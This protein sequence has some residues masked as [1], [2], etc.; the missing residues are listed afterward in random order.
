MAAAAKLL[1]SHISKGSKIFIQIDSDCD[2]YT[3]AAVLINY[4]N[5]L[6]PSFVQNNISYRLHEGKQHGLIPD[7]IPKDVKLIICPDSSSND[8]EEHKYFKENGVD[9][10]VIDHHEAEKVSEYACVINNQLC[11]YPTKSLSGVGMVYKFCCYLDSLLNKEYANTFLDLTA[12]GLIADMMDLRDFETKRLIEKGLQDIKNPFLQMMVAKQEYS[13]GENITPIGIAFYI[14]PYINAIT[15]SGTLEEKML[16]FESMVEYK[17]FELIPSTKRGCKGEQETRVEQACRTCVNVKNR[18]TKARD[19]NLALV[20]KL[21]ED[22]NLLANKIIVVILP[23][24]AE[25]NRNLNGLIAN[26]IM[27]KYQRPVLI[28]NQTER[29]G[30]KWLEGSGRNFDKGGISNLRSTLESYGNS[31]ICYCEGHES[32]FGFGICQNLIEDFIT[33][34]NKKFENID[35]TAKYD[36]DFIYQSQLVKGIDILDIAS[37]KELW[38]QGISEPFVVI[39]NVNITKNNIALMKRNTLKIT[40]PNEKMSFIK[41][42]SSEEEYEKLCAAAGC[43]TIDIVGTCEINSWDNSPQ[44]KIVDYEIV[45]QLDYYF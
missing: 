15:R 28:L 1:I 31:D 26:Q 39:E 23:K 20:E 33:W 6:F 29:N 22:N 18:Q 27:S 43:T 5:T 24:E 10:L 32:A 13:L 30:I 37:Y 8:Y 34:S 19:V 17:A 7:T 11:D 21:I 45:R 35:F 14:A 40:L 38:G 12:T 44:I 16:M 41:F 42:G 25:F 2:G 36:V 9:V 4:L 3:S